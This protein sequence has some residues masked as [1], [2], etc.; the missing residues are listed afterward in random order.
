MGFTGT[1]TRPSALVVVV[2]DD[3]TPVVSSP[4]APALR[5]QAALALAARAD[6]GTGTAMASGVGEVAYQAVEPGLM[7][8]VET[9]TTRHTVTTVL[10]LRLPEE[11]D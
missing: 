9:R 7:A 10:R 11:Q 2:P 4:L 6:T 3:D 1:R 5:A 8:E